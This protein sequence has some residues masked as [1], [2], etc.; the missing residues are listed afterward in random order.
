MSRENQCRE[1]SRERTNTEEMIEWERRTEK[2]AKRNAKSWIFQ[3]QP[4]RESLTLFAL[5]T[6]SSGLEPRAALS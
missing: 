2:F 5:G 3:C 6:G 4:T 1:I